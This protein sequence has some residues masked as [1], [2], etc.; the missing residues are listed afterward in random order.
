MRL[1]TY[2]QAERKGK[3]K[4]DFLIKIAEILEVD[5]VYLLTGK[6]NKV[7]DSEITIPAVIT[8]EPTTAP[9]FEEKE[10]LA[11]LLSRISLTDG[12]LTALLNISSDRRK[13]IYKLIILTVKHRRFDIISEV[14]R[15]EALLETKK[16]L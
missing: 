11:H 15:I 14:E 10:D 7:C 8:T 4:T 13:A 3:I 12:I 5:V 1:S 2:S 16:D 9:K 6:E